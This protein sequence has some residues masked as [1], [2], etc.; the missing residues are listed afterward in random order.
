MA[1]WVPDRHEG[2][3]ILDRFDTPYAELT[4]SLRDIRDVNRF[5]G[6][7]SILLRALTPLLAAAAGPGAGAGTPPRRPLSVL[8]V[9]TG[10]ADNPTAIADWGRARGLDLRVTGLD[11]G[12]DTLRFAHECTAGIAGLSLVRADALRLPFRTGA[13]DF[14]TASLFTHHLTFA[15]FAAL[16]REMARVA[17][18]GVLVNDL[19]RA[20]V[21]WVFIRGWTRLFAR[22]HVTRYDG[23][24]S[25]LKGFTRSEIDAIAARSGVP[26][27]VAHFYFPYRFCLIGQAAGDGSGAGGDGAAGGGGAGG[28][29]NG[30]AL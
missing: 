24:V 8:D 7:T 20:W 16:L 18:R 26:G 22:S 5:L 10:S 28:G 11:L 15:Q 19:V 27:W 3:E 23:P 4:R 17:A 1:F 9:G 2:A 12:A 29:G 6:G 14:V 30:R 25:V 13:Y 21:P